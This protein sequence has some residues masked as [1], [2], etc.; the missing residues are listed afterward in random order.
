MYDFTEEFRKQAETLFMTEMGIR[1]PGMAIEMYGEP[2]DQPESG[3]WVRF[4][5][6]QNPQKQVS[7]GSKFV[8]RTTGFVQI[9][10]MRRR[11]KGKN[12]PMK[13]AEA[14]TDIFAYRKFKG[15]TISISFEEKHVE[16]PRDA[17]EFIRVMGRV[18]FI[19][20]G[21]RQ[22]ETVQSIA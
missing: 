22:R 3:E 12:R 10:V 17:A 13:I 11:E 4:Q 16:A 6:M 9:D 18:F 20:D 2:F 7:L 5:I 1:Y 15:E 19:Y 14:A 8:V 21:T